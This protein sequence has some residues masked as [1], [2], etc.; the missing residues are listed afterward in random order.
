MKKILH[1]LILFFTLASCSDPSIQ[2]DISNLK[3]IEQELPSQSSILNLSEFYTINKVVKLQS[4]D[5]SIIDYVHKI[6][7]DGE[8]IFVK[9]G[10]SLFKF[11]TNG[12][13]VKKLSKGV[14]GPN[15]YVNLTD[16]LLLPEQN[17]IWLYDS[18]QRSIFQYTYDLEMEIDYPLNYPLFGIEKLEKGLVG[19]SGYL[20]VLDNFNS[21]FF[22]EGENLATGYKS[23][24]SHLNFNPEKSK[25]LHVYRH[26][27]FSKAPSG[28]NFINSFNDTIYRV[29][30]LME[31]HP[32]YYVDFGSKKVLEEELTGK[33]YSSIV[34]VFQ[35]INSSEKSYNVSNVVELNR[36]LL[37]KFFNQALPYVSV[38][39][40]EE[41][42]I[43]S[44]RKNAFD[45]LGQQVI[46]DLDEEI[47]FGTLG[48]NKAYLVIPAEASVLKEFQAIFKVEDGDNPLILLFNEK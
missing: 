11:D 32:K 25:Y 24:K 28:Y 36:Y 7:T 15:E 22:F 16:V 23:G 35:Y 38:Y 29:N 21:L 6:M 48:E 44:G 34:D 46:L 1:L 19:T 14:G 30:E 18:N 47:S 33:N 20:D 12:D 45:Y 10:S 4:N 2:S 31:I 42:K 26:D 37:F 17:R 27:Y 8:W 43:Q 39:D 40:K 3:I 9:G 13:F 41:N 5:S